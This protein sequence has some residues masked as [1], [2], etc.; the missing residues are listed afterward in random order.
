MI[1][2]DQEIFYSKSKR[3]QILNS[4]SKLWPCLLPFVLLLIIGYGI[5]IYFYIENNTLID[6]LNHQL[7]Q[8][9]Q[10]SKLKFNNKKK[11]I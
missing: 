11:S 6:Q 7:Q 2:N 1:V 8:T 3:K 5:I 4:L 9:Q 10:K